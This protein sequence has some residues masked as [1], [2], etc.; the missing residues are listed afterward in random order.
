VSAEP[1]FNLCASDALSVLRL[2]AQGHE[3]E[4]RIAAG[5]I[6]APE[7]QLRVQPGRTAILLRSAITALAA[8]L[9]EQD[10]ALSTLRATR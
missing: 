1:G 5:E 6:P 2:L 10:A 8:E 4:V 3:D 7:P 9:A